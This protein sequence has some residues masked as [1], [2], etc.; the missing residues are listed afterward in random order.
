MNLSD[1]NRNGLHVYLK[2][3]KLTAGKYELGVFNRSYKNWTV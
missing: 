3:G 1:T 2:G